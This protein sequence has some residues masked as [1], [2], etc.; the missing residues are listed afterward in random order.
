MKY[1]I[2]GGTFD[3]PHEG[4][5]QIAR[6]AMEALE[7]DEVIFVPTNKNP[8]KTRRVSPANVRLKMVEKAIEDE[9]KM[10]VS[11]IEITRGGPSFAVETVEELSMVRPGDYWFIL[12][13][14]SLATFGNWKDPA[15][16]LLM[17][18]LAAFGRAGRKAED[19]MKHLD[20]EFCRRIDVVAMPN[21][22]VSSSKIREDIARGAPVDRWLKP[23][24]L[25]YIKEIGLYRE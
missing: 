8:L 22:A 23:A 3:P 20:I 2:L 13:S 7:L 1:G 12:G 6:V 17:C 18:R 24:L 9:P 21:I 25:E 16:L 15:K 11:D 19:E 10:S 4:H 5:L 14:D